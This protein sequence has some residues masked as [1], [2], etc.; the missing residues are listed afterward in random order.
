MDLLKRRIRNEGKIVGTDRITVDSFLNHQLDIALLMAIGKEIKRRF[1]PLGINKI[2]TIDASCIAIAAI[3]ATYFDLVPVVCAQKTQSDT[4]TED[5][6]VAELKTFSD[7]TVDTAHIAKQC[8]NAKDR[9]LILDDVLAHGKT[10][11]GLCSL[12]EQAGGTVCGI[13]AIIEKE[14][15][16]GSTKL[17]QAGY[18]VDSLAVITR[19]ENGE[20][21]F[22]D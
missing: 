4:S 1:E 7:K 17:K 6:Y 20:V 8:L 3:T 9:V 11:M 10:A 19:I 18:L 13:T 5:V 21:Y 15:Q 12:V 14:F 22:K 16:G 2:L